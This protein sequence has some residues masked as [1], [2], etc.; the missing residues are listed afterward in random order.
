V[1]LSSGRAGDK[2]PLSS[3]SSTLPHAGI[4]GESQGRR[5]D[6]R[7][8]GLLTEQAG[9]QGVL[10]SS[11]GAQRAEGAPAHPPGGFGTSIAAKMETGV[12]SGAQKPGQC[13]RRLDQPGPTGL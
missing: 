11:C 8:M 1:S 3:R 10:E 6:Q 5:C 12:L 2:L 7:A 4:R 9:G 13:G